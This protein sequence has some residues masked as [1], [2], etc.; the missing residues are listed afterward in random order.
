MRW[1]SFVNRP[2][3]N[4]SPLSLISALQTQIPRTDHQGVAAMHKPPQHMNA[5]HQCQHWAQIEKQPKNVI[6][7]R[8]SVR[9]AWTSFHWIKFGPHIADTVSVSHVF[10]TASKR[11]KSVQRVIQNVALSKFI[12][13]SFNRFVYAKC[14]CIAISATKMFSVSIKTHGFNHK[15]YNRMTPDTTQN[16]TIVYNNKTHIN[17][18]TTTTTKT[19]Q[20]QTHNHKCDLS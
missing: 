15:Y 8:F 6:R 14:W 3:D 9:F 13:S 1:F 17:I 2:A 12:V 19:T 5:L 16:R 18:H 4:E 7:H 20:T 10:G 11:G